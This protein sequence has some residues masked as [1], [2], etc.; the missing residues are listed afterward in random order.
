MLT[1][2]EILLGKGTLGGEQQGEGTQENCSAAWLAV[3]GFMV[4][5]LVSGPAPL[6]SVGFFFLVEAQQIVEILIFPSPVVLEHFPS[7]FPL[8]PTISLYTL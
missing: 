7:Q 4:M 5:G 8:F 1:K 6:S 3:L 2:H